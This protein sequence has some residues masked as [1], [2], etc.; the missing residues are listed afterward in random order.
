MKMIASTRLSKA[1]HA[2]QSEKQYGIANSGMAM[3]FTHSRTSY[4]NVTLQIFSRILNLRRHLNANPL[5]LY[6]QTRVFAAAFI[7]Q[8][9]RT[10]YWMILCLG[11]EMGHITLNHPSIS[12]TAATL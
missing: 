1:Q 11:H 7:L 6:P 5:L 8:S 12:V 4:V 2:M 9:I 3:S 10:C